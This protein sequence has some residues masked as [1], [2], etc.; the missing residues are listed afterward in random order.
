[1]FIKINVM[2]DQIHHH[3]LICSSNI[4]FHIFILNFSGYYM[5]KHIWFEFEMV[6]ISNAQVQFVHFGFLVCLLRLILES[7]NQNNYS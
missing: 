1:M 2:H 4:G 7:P 6:Q 5:A 3:Y